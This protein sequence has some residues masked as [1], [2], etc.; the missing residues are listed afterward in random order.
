MSK[1]NEKKVIVSPYE[2][3]ILTNTL[4][5]VQNKYDSSAPEAYQKAK[6]TKNPSFKVEN[7][8]GAAVW[9]DVKKNWDTAL[10]EDSNLLRE[11]FAGNDLSIVVKSLK[12]Y[13]VKENEKNLGKDKLSHIASNETND[14]WDSY[15]INYG[16]GTVF[17]TADPKDLMDLY[18]LMVKKRLTP[19][20]METHPEFLGSQ[21]IIVNQEGALSREAEAE[22]DRMESI[23]TFYALLQNKKEDLLTILDYVG[24]SVSSETDK[25]TLV[26]IFNNW[27]D[28][29]Q[30]EVV[31]KNTV[32]KYK[33]KEGEELFFIFRTL[34][35]F[36]KKNIVT[37]KADKIYL[38]GEF[39]ENGWKNAA[40]KIASD[41][42]LKE[43]FQKFL[44]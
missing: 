8:E 15:Q 31:F 33:S 36:R 6:V 35:E 28:K 34:K 2:F 12:E 27:V 24:L 41:S 42:E 1:K 40:E 10:Y 18:Y 30:N 16:A 37:L 7:R 17:N 26:K 22:L 32:N 19:K 23:A 25:A 44:N 39:I 9:D 43:L 20:E 13:I 11:A 3:D 21:Y 14:F 4:Y 29:G 5:E 38:D